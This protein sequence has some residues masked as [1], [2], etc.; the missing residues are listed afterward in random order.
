MA[1]IIQSRANDLLTN[2]ESLPI[3]VELIA[4]RLNI[5]VIASDLGEEISGL[6]VIED[7]KT[8][9]G[10]NKTESKVRNRFTIAHELGHFILHKNSSDLFVD[11][12]FK[13]LF[14]STKQDNESLLIRKQEHEANEF[15]ACLLMPAKMV[16]AEMSKLG[17]EYIDAYDEATIKQLAK[18]FDV[19]TIAMS[20][21]LLNL[22]YRF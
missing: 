12:H 15:A 14:R 13:V 3:P 21:R 7:D 2:N 4:M 8:V 11:K 22:G 6:L 19:S 17:I 9:I 1:N 20:L 5:N 16:E 18:I 10:Y